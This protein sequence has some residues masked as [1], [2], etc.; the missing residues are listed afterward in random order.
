MFFTSAKPNHAFKRF[1]VVT[2]DSFD[3]HRNIKI[4]N[5]LKESRTFL[6]TNSHQSNTKMLPLLRS[7]SPT[8]RRHF[9]NW[10]WGKNVTKHTPQFTVTPY[11]GFLPRQD[12]LD[13]LPP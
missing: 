11:N 7:R 6:E 10:T 2:I 9:S 1:Q 4:I 3:P 13:E 8:T 12:P 5:I